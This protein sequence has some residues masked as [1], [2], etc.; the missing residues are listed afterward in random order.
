MYE[1][2]MFKRLSKKF[3][4]LAAICQK[5]A[6]L[7]TQNI[8]AMSHSQYILHLALNDFFLHPYL[9]TEWSMFFKI[10]RRG[11]CIQNACFRQTSIKVI[12]VFRQLIQTDEK[13]CRSLWGIFWDPINWLLMINSCLSSL[14]SIYW[15]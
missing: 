10:W 7:S 6:F 1:Y 2:R 5:E 9:K 4:A 13:V 8:D 14:I 15:G 3:F 11:C 12:K